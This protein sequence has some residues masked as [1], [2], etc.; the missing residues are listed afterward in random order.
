MERQGLFAVL[1]ARNGTVE[2][3]EPHRAVHWTGEDEAR[4]LFGELVRGGERLART[5]W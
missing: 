4:R 1:E 3:A 5:I 2:G